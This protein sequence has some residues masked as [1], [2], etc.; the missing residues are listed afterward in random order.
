VKSLALTLL[1]ALTLAA[2]AAAKKPD[3]VIGSG[4]ASLSGKSISATFAVR[5][6]GG[7]RAV[8]SS[9]LL[10]IGLPGYGEQ[11]VQT[12]EVKAMKKGKK[13][14]VTITGEVPADF[15]P[16][17]YN[18]TAC[19]DPDGYVQERN[20]SN[21]CTKIGQALVTAKPTSG[22]P[23]TPSGPVEFERDQP[24]QLESGKSSYWAVVPSGYEKNTPSRLL[25]WLHGCGNN[26]EGDIYTVAPSDG[27]NY[28]AIAV[29][30]RDGECWDV[31]QD[32][33]TVLAAIANLKTHFNIDP[34]RIVL[35]GFSSG[36]DLTYRTAFY[37]STMFAGILVAGSTPF[38][39]TDSTQQASIA[40]ATFKFHVVHLA[41]I[42]DEAYQIATVRQ[43]TDA[44]TAAGFPMERV[45]RPGTHFDE[46]GEADLKAVLL[47]HMTDNWMAPPV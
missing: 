29:G 28:I 13:R 25:V 19:A 15:K 30:G 6:S 34:R 38:R 36:G 44:L 16:L 3:L 14:T 27:R 31:N 20:E 22:G 33:A 26:S 8:A 7:R 42:D 10:N 2:P 21:N 23:A 12:V 32:S 11:I 24:F 40:A 45:E 43:E 46:N 35:G 4:T 1:A 41:H 17:T 18:L 5:N 47:P 9:A 39:D 37:N